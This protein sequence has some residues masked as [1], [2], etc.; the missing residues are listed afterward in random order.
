MSDHGTFQ[1]VQYSNDVNDHILYSQ[2]LSELKSQTIQNPKRLSVFD[3]L[4]QG[5]PLCENRRLPH[6]LNDCPFQNDNPKGNA[7]VPS[8]YGMQQERC[9]KSLLL[10]TDSSYEANEWEIVRDHF[11]NSRCKKVLSIIQQ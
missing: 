7:S 4:C 8:T 3:S 11:E 1:I 5:I 2:Q 6:I 10:H 9:W